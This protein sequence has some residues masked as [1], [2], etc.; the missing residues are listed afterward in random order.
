[1]LYE[2]DES[3]REINLSTHGPDFVAVGNFDWDNT[4]VE[5][6]VRR[7]YQEN[8]YIAVGFLGNRLTVLVFTM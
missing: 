5:Q 8:R 7:E 2:W 4:S 6:D 1:M 3:K